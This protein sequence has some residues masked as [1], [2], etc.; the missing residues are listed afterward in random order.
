MILQVEN[1]N[2]F[3]GK[4]HILYDVSLDIEKDEIVALLGRNGAGKSTTLKSIIGIQHAKSGQVILKEK[5]VTDLPTHEI[6]KRGIAY[7]PEERRVFHN[8][9]VLENLQM[10]SLRNPDVK[11]TEVFEWVFSFFP[12]LNERRSQKAGSL[13]GGEQQMLTI[14][15]GLISDPDLML[16]DEPTEG[17]MPTLV[18][19]IEERLL[20]LKKEGI[21][22]LL[23]E[24]N[25]KLALNVADRAYFIEK[26][27]IKEEGN[28]DEF[29][30]N[31][32]IIQNYLSVR[33]QE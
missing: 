23:V 2:T 32:E 16:I 15:R 21:S 12:R 7:V 13:S 29:L 25:A 11:I 28:A 4:S 27:V 31:E 17:L 14:A 22:I 26:G 5:K 1:I 30:S 10:G 8:L 20:E 19:E 33:K 18:Q 24:Q 9:S 6:A 3:Y